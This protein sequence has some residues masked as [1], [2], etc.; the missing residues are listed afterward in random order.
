MIPYYWTTNILF[1]Y[2]QL[3]KYFLVVCPS[4]HTL[5]VCPD[6]SYFHWK[7]I[8]AARKHGTAQ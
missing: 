3:N 2:W 5:S 4:S 1:F 6:Y 7:I 8:F